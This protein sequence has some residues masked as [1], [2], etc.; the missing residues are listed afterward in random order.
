MWVCPNDQGWLYN[1]DGCW[2]QTW[3]ITVFVTWAA[4]AAYFDEAHS[5]IDSVNAW[6]KRMGRRFDM[7]GLVRAVNAVSSQ[8]I[9]V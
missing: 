4:F 9:A 1:P 5:V 6:K 7:A 8:Q 3:D 2:I